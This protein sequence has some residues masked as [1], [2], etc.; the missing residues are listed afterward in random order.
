MLTVIHGEQLVHSRHK[1]A[2]VKA[3]YAAKA[4]RSTTVQG[5]ELTLSG[6][7][8]LLQRTS[9][10]EDQEVLVIEELHS[11]P[12][13]K[14]KTALIECIAAAQKDC[15]LWEKRDLTATMLKPF[16]KAQVFAFPLSKKLFAFVEKLGSFASP[17]D[18]LLAA[19]QVY[20]QDGAHFLFAMLCRQVRMLIAAHDDGTLKGAPF[21]IAKLKK[22]AQ[23]F[24]LPTLLVL[25]TRLLEIDLAE[26]QSTSALTLEQ[27][28]DLFF[29]SL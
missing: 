4:V 17:Q 6:L 8:E 21:M 10:F 22:Q 7:Q 29:M 18:C 2:E 11:L 3:A 13:S 12:P 20:A 24:S 14:H 26:K 25:H 5:K 28:L 27:Q 16:A 15:I 19:H 9:L 23:H 1:L